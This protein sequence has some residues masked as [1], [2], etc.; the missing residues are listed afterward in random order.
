M[1]V[2]AFT[3]VCEEDACWLPQYLAEAERIGI[4]FVMHL[5]R[6]SRETARIV[7]SHR[8][9]A[10]ITRQDNHA[11]Q[12]SETD[13]Q[14][15]LDVVVSSGCRWALAWDVDETYAQDARR[16]LEN[17]GNYFADLL[18]VRM[19]NLWGDD[20]H[21]RVDGPFSSAWRCKLYRIGAGNS[22]AFRHPL[23]NG[24]VDLSGRHANGT[25]QRTGLVCLHHGFKT[26][27]LRLAHRERWNSIYGAAFG[28]N[29]YGTWDWVCDETIA[30][31][32]RELVE[33]LAC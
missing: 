10:G 12:F 31:T 14:A 7:E 23:V 21:A 26:Q 1:N 5:D 29:P 24:A 8:L 32:V 15:A 22:W 9:L 25:E 19:V 17:L 20:L 27:T 28:Y 18:Q 2:C 30:P 16:H 3:S 33:E 6:C 11:K 13:K 4:Q